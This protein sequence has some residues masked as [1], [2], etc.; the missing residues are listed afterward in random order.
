MSTPH[1]LEKY[2]LYCCDRLL[3]AAVESSPFWPA[4]EC[5]ATSAEGSSLRLNRVLLGESA[6][7]FLACSAGVQL[8]ACEPSPHATVVVPIKGTIEIETATGIVRARPA[9]PVLLG[10]GWIRRL[11]AS[12][13]AGVMVSFPASTLA[14][15]TAGDAGVSPRQ[16]RLLAGAVAAALRTEALGLARAAQASSRLEPLQSLSDADR[17]RLLS[18]R[19]RAREARLLGN[20]AAAWLAPESTAVPEA[21]GE[22]SDVAHWLAQHALSREPL[23]ELARRA[24]R[25]LR[26]I[27]RACRSLGSTPQDVLRDARL[28]RARAML[29]SSAATVS[30]ADVAQSVGYRH[31]GRFAAYYRDR[32]REMPSETLARS[33]RQPPE[34]P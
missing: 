1:L 4:H 11:E 31:L 25:S 12:A 10:A 21:S 30:V 32:F 9:Q 23:A 3:P 19:L 13:A 34:S 29:E 16:S 6:L 7:T 24:G 20:L 5:V 27:Q 2:P 14:S 17:S 28:D 26:S 15:A 18:T 33:R 8:R 22:A